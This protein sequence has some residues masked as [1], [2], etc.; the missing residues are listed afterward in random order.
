MLP[1]QESRLQ[2]NLTC[3]GLLGIF[4]FIGALGSSYAVQD[5]TRPLNYYEFITLH[6]MVESSA[7]R[8]SVTIDE[9]TARVLNRFRVTHLQEIPAYEWKEVLA[10]LSMSER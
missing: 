3:L 8:T 7:R 4:L 9:M 5:F 10:Y 2:M 6:S 1:R